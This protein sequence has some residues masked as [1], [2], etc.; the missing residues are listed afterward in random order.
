MYIIRVTLNVERHSC[1]KATYSQ[2]GRRL[3]ALSFAS[4]SS[5]VG[6]ES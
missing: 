2:T 5:M 3:L 4:L 6:V 1:K